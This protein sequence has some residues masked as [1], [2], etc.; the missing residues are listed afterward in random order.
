MLDYSISLTRG[1]ITRQF[2]FRRRTQRLRVAFVSPQ[3]VL[4]CHGGDGGYVVVVD[5]KDW[6][7]RGVAAA[8]GSSIFI[9]STG[10]KPRFGPTKIN[11]RCT[12][13]TRS[14]NRIERSQTLKRRRQRRRCLKSVTPDGRRACHSPQSSQLKWARPENP[15]GQFLDGVSEPGPFVD[16]GANTI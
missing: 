10:N 13:R 14:P 12:T 7:R 8:A 16:L 5:D 3:V 2:I 11:L 1:L 9:T 6:R 15:S 4:N